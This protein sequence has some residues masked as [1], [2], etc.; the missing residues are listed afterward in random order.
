[1]ATYNVT[2][3][4]AEEKAL[5]EELIDAAG[6]Q[7]WLDNAIQE[8]A[9]RSMHVILLRDT[10]LRKAV[11]A[12]EQDKVIKQSAGKVIKLRKSAQ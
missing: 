4:D 11:K 2:I 5:T 3:S 6:I 7:A 12:M 8:K 1:M 10:D 9:R